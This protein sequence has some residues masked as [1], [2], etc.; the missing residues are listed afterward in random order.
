MTN[1]MTSSLERKLITQVCQNLLSRKTKKKIDRKKGLLQIRGGCQKC[2]RVS[3][4]N[5]W[6]RFF[7]VTFAHILWIPSSEVDPT[8]DCRYTIKPS[9]PLNL[10]VK[11]NPKNLKPIIVKYIQALGYLLVCLR[12]NFSK[13]SGLICS[14]QEPSIRGAITMPSKSLAVVTQRY[15]Q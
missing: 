13:R 11:V 8:T 10:G 2:L 7:P 1:R 14:L 6:Y 9:F 5:F 15:L 12:P 3:V 4:L